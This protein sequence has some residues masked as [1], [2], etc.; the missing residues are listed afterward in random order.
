M[1]LIE[2]MK[3]I[4]DLQRK[5]SDLHGKIAAHSAHLNFETPAYTNQATKVAEWLQGCSDLIEEILRLRVA[6]QRT[7]LVTPVT[8]ELGGKQVTHSIA[9]WI[10]RRRDLASL[11][12]NGW[13]S[14]TTKNLKE[15]LTKDSSGA[16]VEVRIVRCFNTEKRDAMQALFMS[17]PSTIDASLEVV[18]AV[19]EII[20]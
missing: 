2:A 12:L 1:K 18:N 10:H 14:L 17:E 8:I 13:H 7:N 11:E 19:T 6:V 3:K 9:E 16:T 20:E 4:K 15:G 5:V